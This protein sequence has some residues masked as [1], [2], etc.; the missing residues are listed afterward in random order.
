[1]TATNT[2]AT[3][4]QTT[5]APAGLKAFNA[6]V[7]NPKTQ[8]YLASVLAEKKSQYV[9]NIVALVANSDNLQQCEPQS[10]MFAGIKATA[11]N[12]PLDPN[13]GYA[14][15]VPYWDNSTTPRTRK[16]Q[17]Q[18]GYKGLIQ[19]ALRSG[20]ML[21]L[22]TTDIREGELVEQN[23]LTGDMTVRQVPDRMNKKIIG[24]AAY[25]KLT[26]GFEKSFYSTREQIEDFANTRSKQKDRNGRLIG[27][28]V[29]DFDAM[30]KKTVL[31]ALLKYAPLSTEMM[32]ALSN[33]QDGDIT[34]SE[35]MPTDTI[36]TEAISMDDESTAPTTPPPAQPTA[37]TT[38]TAQPQPNF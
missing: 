7:Q 17:F 14:Y 21:R 36:E 8:D 13:L 27:T 10:I 1:M 3:A 16:A 25:M 26:N 4:T 30:A 12:L 33:D 9:N 37:P 11:L 34:I 31:K 6:L 5:Q 19:L 22:N 2:P 18:I 20:Q 32:D 24:Y 23:I 38:A 35:E 28:W 15:I 29:S